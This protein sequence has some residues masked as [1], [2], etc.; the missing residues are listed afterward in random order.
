MGGLDPLHVI[1]R[2]NSTILA[3]KIHKKLGILIV[4]PQDQTVR[5]DTL[6][7]NKTHLKSFWAPNL[8][9]ILKSSLVIQIWASH[10]RPIC[11]FFPFPTPR[12]LGAVQ[13]CVL[14]RRGPLGDEPGVR[15][16]GGASVRHTGPDRPW[17][18][19][20]PI[21]LRVRAHHA[22]G[23]AVSRGQC[24]LPPLHREP[25]GRLVRAQHWC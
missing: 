12:T 20:F 6:V 9:G 3:N 5:K 21:R 1:S 2:A 8:F 23:G 11:V 7:L 24:G 25:D 17:L 10:R 4:R 13:Q 15:A 22:L 18:T 16:V 14:R 19:T